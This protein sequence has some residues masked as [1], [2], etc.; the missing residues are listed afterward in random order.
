[1]SKGEKDN[2]AKAITRIYSRVGMPASYVQV[3][4]TQDGLGDVF[5]GRD[6]KA[7]H[8]V[9]QIYHI[10]R[11]LP[12][13]EVQVRFPSKA[14]EVLNPVFGTKG[15]DWECWITKSLRELWKTNGIV[16]PPMGTEVE[17]KSKTE[18]TS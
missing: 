8:A 1:M 9:V 18:A 17:K 15:V 2:L 11:K 13:E 6:A 4:F 12:S 3:R 10:A 16:P 14:D 7:K 5:V